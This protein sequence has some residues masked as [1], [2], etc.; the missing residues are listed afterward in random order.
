M[1]CIANFLAAHQTFRG[2]HGDR[3]HGVFTQVL[4]HFEHQPVTAVIGFQGVQD[5]RQFVLELNIDD[6]AHYLP[7]LTGPCYVC[8]AIGHLF[9]SLP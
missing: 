1:A 6:G 3:A 4:G 7:D 2:I 5:F 9:E 8:I